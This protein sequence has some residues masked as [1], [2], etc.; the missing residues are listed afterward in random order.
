M[1]CNHH[2]AVI[3]ERGAMNAHAQAVID[4]NSND[5]IMTIAY[6]LWTKQFSDDPVTNWH[7]AE[8][9][10]QKQQQNRPAGQT[11]T[12]HGSTESVSTKKKYY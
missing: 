1:A 4:E 8:R 7:A 6:D 10:Y 3:Q 12:L 5:A 9:T 2:A 11:T